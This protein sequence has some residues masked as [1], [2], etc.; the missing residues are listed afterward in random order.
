[1]LCKSWLL[2][3]NVHVF[4]DSSKNLKGL[5]KD[6]TTLSHSQLCLLKMLGSRSQL[7][8]WLLICFY[9]MHARISEKVHEFLVACI[10]VKTRPSS[11]S[12]ALRFDLMEISYISLYRK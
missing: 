9:A 4:V 5:I 12:L 7:T 8:D 2:F 6:K 1:M 11:N 10:E 3:L